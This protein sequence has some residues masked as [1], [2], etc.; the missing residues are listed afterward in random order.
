M[1]EPIYASLGQTIRA[2]R[3]NRCMDQRALADLLG[4]QR[5][6]SISD[7]E[8]GRARLQVH[9]LL[10]LSEVFEVSPATLLS[11]TIEER[12]GK[13]MEVKEQQWREY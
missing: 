7:I 9:Q 10:Q 6:S 12:Q 4:Y 2:L 8:K 5:V 11:G 13:A 3:R 1:I